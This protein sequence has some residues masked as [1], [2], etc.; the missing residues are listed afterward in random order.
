VIAVAND[1]TWGSGSFSPAE[2][3][4]FRAAVETSLEERLPLVY[5]AANAG[6]RVGLATEVRDCLQVAWTDPAQPELGWDYLYLGEKDYGRLVRD[7]PPGAPPVVRAE[8][9]KEAEGGEGPGG[10]RGAFG[11][12]VRGN[13]R[14]WPGK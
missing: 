9:R 14:A 2:D 11:V 1:I 10:P 3:A 13:R 6:A 4:V 5:L 12:C 7:V 8:V